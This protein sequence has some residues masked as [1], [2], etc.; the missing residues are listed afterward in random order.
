VHLAERQGYDFK[1][2]F[3]DVDPGSPRWSFLGEDANPVDDLASLMAVCDDKLGGLPSFL[4]AL[5]A[6]QC[7]QAVP[8]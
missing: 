5:S 1:D 3:V 6:S 4:Q 7:K 2:G 8:L